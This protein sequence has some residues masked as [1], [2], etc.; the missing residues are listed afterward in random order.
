MLGRDT[1]WRQGHLLTREAAAALGLVE[2][3][4]GVCRAIVVTHDCDLA[5]DGEPSVEV[6]VAGRVPGTDGNLSY[7]KN[8][9]RLHVVFQSN[10][11]APL[12]LELQHVDRRSQAYDPRYGISRS[13]PSI[14]TT[15]TRPPSIVTLPRRRVSPVSL[16]SN[17]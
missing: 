12:V 5:H 13:P 16:N 4:D 6:I 15:S 17:T 8:P 9:R 2:P 3:S 10:Q 11:G 1:E 14:A 7:A